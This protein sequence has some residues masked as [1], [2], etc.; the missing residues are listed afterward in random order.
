MDLV[1]IR[2]ATKTGSSR[3]LLPRNNIVS[4][5]LA[6]LFGAVITGWNDVDVDAAL[7]DDVGAHVER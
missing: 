4:E 2:P 7:G 6:R 5:D 3:G 1:R